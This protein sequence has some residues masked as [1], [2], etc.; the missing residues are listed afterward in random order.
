[1]PRRSLVYA[2]LTLTF[3]P[4][5]ARPIKT[6]T[7]NISPLPTP[8]LPFP[9]PPQ[10]PLLLTQP[11]HPPPQSPHLP[12]QL[13]HARSITLV[14][15]HQHGHHLPRHMRKPLRHHVRSPLL[16]P[17]SLFRLSSVRLPDPAGTVRP[18]A[19]SVKRRV[20]SRS[21]AQTGTGCRSAGWSRAPWMSSG[22]RAR[23]A[24]VE[25]RRVRSVSLNDSRGDGSVWG[26]L[27][28]CF[29]ELL[30][31]LLLWLVH[32]CPC[33]ISGIYLVFTGLA[34]M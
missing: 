28:M 23:R 14:H 7:L 11:L 4:F 17:L 34:T 29:G 26:A 8:I 1:M 12:P 32:D 9:H 6:L 33:P 25:G 5:N 27:G 13:I 2:T 15:V 16:P 10:Q 19:V 21:A 20:S 3:Y 18:A 31:S 24:G 30:R 22:G